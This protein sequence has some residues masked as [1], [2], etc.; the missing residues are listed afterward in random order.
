MNVVI[1]YLL[2]CVGLGLI[3]LNTLHYKRELKKQRGSMF[4]EKLMVNH[5][6]SQFLAEKM[7]NAELRAEVEYLTL[8]LAAAKLGATVIETCGYEYFDGMRCTLE[9]DRHGHLGQHEWVG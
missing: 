1:A 3:G 5:F 6:S 2:I 9:Y 8:E 7:T 4:F